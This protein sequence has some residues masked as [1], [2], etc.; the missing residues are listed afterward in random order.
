MLVLL[1]ISDNEPD[2]T[3]VSWLLDCPEN[4]G[5]FNDQL[6]WDQTKEKHGFKKLGSLD[7]FTQQIKMFIE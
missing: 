3:F 6:I 2:T 7:T 4:W 5:S 1:R